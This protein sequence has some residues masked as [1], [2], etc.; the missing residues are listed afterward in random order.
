MAVLHSNTSHKTK[1]EEK[2]DF[3]YAPGVNWDSLSPEIT[4]KET[5]PLSPKFKDT[6]THLWNSLFS[7]QQAASCHTSVRFGGWFSCVISGSELCTTLC[8]KTTPTLRRVSSLPRKHANPGP[9]LSL[10]TF[11]NCIC[12]CGVLVKPSQAERDSFHLQ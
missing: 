4:A 5:S 9:C 10:W 7:N 2:K 11:N 1:G 6:S 3:I 8:G 12:S